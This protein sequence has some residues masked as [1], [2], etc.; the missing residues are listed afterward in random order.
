MVLIGFHH[1]LSFYEIIEKLLFYQ[2]DE[3][4]NYFRKRKYKL[5]KKIQCK[6]CNHTAKFYV[7]NYCL[8]CCI[9]LPRLYFISEHIEIINIR[10]IKFQ[11]RKSPLQS[12]SISDYSIVLGDWVEYDINLLEKILD[13]ELLLLQNYFLVLVKT[14]DDEIKFVQVPIS[15]YR[16]AEKVVYEL[17]AGLN[18]AEDIKPAILTRLGI[19]K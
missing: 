12:S 13:I 16:M 6:L 7:G 3:A 8:V 9:F 19:L 10:E 1:Q 18:I 14:T 11:R 2:F 17:F 5:D 15:I 4:W